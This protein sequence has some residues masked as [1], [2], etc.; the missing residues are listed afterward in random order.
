MTRIFISYAHIDEYRVRELA[1]ILRAAGHDPWFDH[2][3]MAN[4]DWT[5]KLSDAIQSSDRFLYALTPESVESRWCQWE[6]AQAVHARKPV[7]LVLVQANT[8]LSGVLGRIQYADFSRG[9]DPR[10]VA[11]LLGGVL[12]AQVIAPDDVPIPSIQPE[13]LY[14]QIYPSTD[15]LFPD[16]ERELVTVAEGKL[17]PVVDYMAS[18]LATGILQAPDSDVLDAA[19]YLELQKRKLAIEQMELEEMRRRI[20]RLESSHERAEPSSPTT[21]T[22]P[23]PVRQLMQFQQRRVWWALASLIVSAV[24]SMGLA[25]LGVNMAR[26]VL[27]N[28]STDS[29]GSAFTILAV[30]MYV[31][32]LH[33]S[34]RLYRARE[35][36][37]REQTVNYLRLRD[38]T[39]FEQIEADVNAVLNSS[40]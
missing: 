33:Y 27:P 20:Q 11:N 1:N 13:E 4:R 2:K 12:D 34:T 17:F 30:L 38:A 16:L 5:V 31:S 3:L 24:A 10:G 35:D 19:T 25:L 14:P 8:P 18:R 9:P 26:D 37:Y 21:Q 28:V 32:M 40:P 23:E 29:I 22:L 39:F 36:R 15:A 7:L 6:F